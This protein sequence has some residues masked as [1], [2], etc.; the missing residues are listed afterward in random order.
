MIARP[1]VVPFRPP[2]HFPDFG[3]VH[4]NLRRGFAV[5]RTLY[6]SVKAKIVYGDELLLGCS[7]V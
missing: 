2:N 6:E 4:K 3:G 1:S 7:V 5:L